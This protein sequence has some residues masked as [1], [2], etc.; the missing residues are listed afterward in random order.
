MSSTRS[1]SWALFSQIMYENPKKQTRVKIFCA[2]ILTIYGPEGKSHECITNI[3]DNV[4]ANMFKCR[5][6]ID[7]YIHCYLKKKKRV[8]KYALTKYI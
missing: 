5:N 8:Q 1:G 3:T 2:F 4:L 6:M 7:C